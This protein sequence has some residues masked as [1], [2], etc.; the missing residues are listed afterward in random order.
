MSSGLVTQ[1]RLDMIVDLPI[2]LAQAKLPRATSIVMASIVVGLGQRLRLGWLSLQ[3]V[4]LSATT[5]SRLNTSLGIAYVGVFAG[6]AEL[7]RIP[8]GT[9]LCVISLNGPFVKLLN[10]YVARDMEGPDVVNVVAVNNTSNVDMEVVV[11]GSA[12]LYT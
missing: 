10:P 11:T 3:L 4:R 7:A 6:G 9:A 5:P 1:P 12:K 8:T 2:G